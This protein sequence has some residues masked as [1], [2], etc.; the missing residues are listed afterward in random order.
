MQAGANIEQVATGKIIMAASGNLALNADG[1]LQLNGVGGI[2]EETKAGAGTIGNYSNWWKKT[3][4]YIK[5]KRL[6]SNR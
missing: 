3:N 2:Y 5:L 4:K 6:T 1:Q